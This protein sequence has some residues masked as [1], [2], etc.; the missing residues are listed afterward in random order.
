MFK[1]VLL[2][3]DLAHKEE[4]EAA[5]VAAKDYV[6]AGCNLYIVSVI[7]PL[8]GGGFVQSFLPA[9]YDKSLIEKGVEA[10][11]EY[12]ASYFPQ[13]DKIKHI[14]VH[15]KVYEKITDIADQLD[16]NLII[17]MASIKK[18]R[19]SSG[20]GPNVARIVRNSDCSVLVLR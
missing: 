14:V 1:N 17:T 8:E 11:H 4:Q 6:E 3:V 5:M 2:A 20:F 12:T 9:D 13:S 10:L 18:D 15:G 7:P 19:Q 16:I